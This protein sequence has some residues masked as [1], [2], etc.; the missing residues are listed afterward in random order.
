MVGAAMGGMEISIAI[1]GIQ[2][3]GLLHA[4]V[5]LSNCFSS[6]S[7]AL[8]FAMG[9]AP[10]SDIPFW[11]SVSSAYV[12]VSVLAT[13]EPTSQSMITG[14]VDTVIVD[15]I[16]RTV[17]IEGRDLSSSLIDAYRQEDVVNQSASEV[18]S[19]IAQH[20]GLSAVVTPTSGNVGRYYGDGYTRLS[21]GQF[22]RLRSDWDLVVQLARENSFDVFVEGTTLFFQPST[23]ALAVPVRI[24]PQN[25][26]AMR[27]ERAL[28][29][30]SDV[31]ARVQSWNSQNMTSYESN[32]NT[33]T[34]EAVPPPQT[35]GSQ[36]FLFS[37][38]NFTLQQ[39]TLTAERYASELVR[40]ST[41][42]HLEM[43]WD[44]SLSPRMSI[45]LDDTGSS[46]DGMYRIDA[47][48]R[49][50]NSIS[51]STQNIRAIHV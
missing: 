32:N 37:A 51:G 7:Y 36:P 44:L 43:P 13:Y 18:V 50:Y 47:I 23:D 28:A 48:E 46:F 25:V 2:I 17:S 39:T 5:T 1:N 6:D 8:T 45:L 19:A 33:N 4:T 41:V 31:K 22:S 16:H 20:H 12:E 27:I 26:Q 42:L 24:A 38:S 34:T 10:L 29:I 30:N 14:M 35:S 15:P 21:L 9:P 3:Q 11:A 40:L 49:H